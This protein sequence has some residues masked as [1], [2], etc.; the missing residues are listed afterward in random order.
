MAMFERRW[1]H[2]GEQGDSTD[3]LAR[4]DHI[5]CLGYGSTLHLEESKAYCRSQEG[6]EL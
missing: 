3:C 4:E 2:V 1:W 6:R 5:C